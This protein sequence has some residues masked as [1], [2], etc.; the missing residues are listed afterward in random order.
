M[1]SRLDNDTLERIRDDLDDDDPT[2]R[3]QAVDA[4]ATLGD[5]PGLLRALGAGDP[6][7]R[8]VA[9]RGLATEA[10]EHV[11]WRLAQGIWD[12]EPRVRVEVAR[13]LGRRSG[14]LPVHAL[15]RLAE[16]DESPLVRAAALCAYAAASFPD[17]IDL[18]C[19][20]AAEDDAPEV[21]A[22]ASEL[23]ARRPAT[24]RA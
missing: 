11:T 7:V 5:T 22:Q 6:D 23:I 1:T 20:A 17:A 24:G 10:G 9:L 2:R 16:S 18:L 4:L 3:A 19:T 15:R 13:A 8:C 14:W 12:A 21:R